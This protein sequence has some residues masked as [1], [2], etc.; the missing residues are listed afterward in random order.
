MP[1]FFSLI[2][3]LLSMYIHMVYMYVCTYDYMCACEPVCVCLCVH[4]Y[5]YSYMETRVCSWVSSLVALHLI[6]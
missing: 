4:K 2:F 3:F 1:D 6:C 5:V